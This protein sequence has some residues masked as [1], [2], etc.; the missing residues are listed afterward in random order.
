FIQEHIYMAVPEPPYILALD[1]GTSSVRTGLFDRLGR[2]VPEVESSLRHAPETTPDG[3][4]EMDPEGLVEAV[5]WVLASGLAQA[6][7]RAGEIAGV[8]ICTFWHSF[9]GLDEAEQPTTP[10]LMWAD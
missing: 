8:G 9:L 1:V 7:P 2:T 5:C 6:G 4:V 10:I 3:G